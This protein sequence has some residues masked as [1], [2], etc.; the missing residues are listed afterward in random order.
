VR[1]HLGSGGFVRVAVVCSPLVGGRT[2]VVL[3]C[4]GRYLGGG[5]SDFRIRLCRMEDLLL[6]VLG[7]LSLRRRSVRFGAQAFI[8][9]MG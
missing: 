8:G 7:G 5:R 1:A 6:C 2:A 4:R 9:E 3:I